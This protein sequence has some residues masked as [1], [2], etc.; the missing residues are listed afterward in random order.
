MMGSVTVDR[1]EAVYRREHDR[2]W[3]SLVA[4]TG[5]TDLASDAEAEAFAQLIGRGDAVK[6]PAAWVWRSAYRIAAGLL[7]RSD[8]AGPVPVLVTIDDPSIVDLLDLLDGLSPQQRAC[9]V[10][11]YVGRFTSPEIADFLGTT[12]GTVR[13]QLH[14]AHESLRVTL[15]DT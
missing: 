12:D 2:L 14:R 15:E 3:R 1:I 5:D 6:D 9:V 10:L 7:Q 13:V 4:Y 11:R 8:S